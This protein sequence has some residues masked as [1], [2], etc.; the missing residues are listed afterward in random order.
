MA[1]CIMTRCD[2]CADVFISQHILISL[3]AILGSAT[4]FGMTT[5]LGLL[6]KDY[7]SSPPSVD[8][9]RLSWATSIFYFGMLAGL[10]PMTF[11]LQRFNTRT[12]LG[13]V[14]LV[15]AIVCAATAG[16]TTWQGLFVQRFFLGMFISNVL[17]YSLI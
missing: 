16:V 4:L 8:T 3:Q 5:D 12:V 1:W 17:C 11:I 14:V 10:Y 15:W 2:D 13:P 7:S 6:V 9:S